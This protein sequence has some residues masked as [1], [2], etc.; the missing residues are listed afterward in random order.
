[1]IPTDL[2]L[3][4]RIKGGDKQAFTELFDRYRNRILG[5]L[6]RYVGNYHTAEDL[7]VATFWNVY[8]NIARYEECGKFSSWLYKIATNCA[9]RELEN[10]GKNREVLLDPLSVEGEKG[11]DLSEMALDEKNRPEGIYL[12]YR[13]KA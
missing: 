12:S 5:Y 13:L 4:E 11:L 9:K 10:K 1:M 3:I 8:N 7:T 6:Y 2:E